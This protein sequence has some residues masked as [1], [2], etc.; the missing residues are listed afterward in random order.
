MGSQ[1]APDPSKMARWSA[2]AIECPDG[3]ELARDASPDGE[4]S[5]LWCQLVRGGQVAP[6]GPYLELYADGSTARQGL[7]R[8]GRQVGP[9]VVWSP[10]GEVES[11]RML[12]PG[13]AN[14]FIPRPEDLCPPGTI[15]DRSRG[16]DHKRRL[17]SHCHR[18]DA[19]GKEVR[20][21]P[22]VTWD[23]ETAS[24]GGTRFAL[25]EIEMYQDG[26]RHGPRQVFAG[27]SGQEALV[28]EETLEADALEGVS[29]AFFL[30]GTVREVR[31][32]AQG[33]LHGERIG[34]APQGGERWRVTYENGQVVATEGDLT[35]GGQ[36][37]PERTVP[38]VS[39]DGREEACARRYPYSIWRHGP[40]LVRDGQGQVVER[41]LYED[42]HKAQLWQAPPG[43]EIPAPVSDD[44]LVARIELL[45]G[46]RSYPALH[47]RWK[48]AAA[49]GALAEPAAAPGAS[50]TAAFEEEITVREPVPHKIWFRNN[51]TKKYPHPRTEIRD[52]VVE[53]YGL[54]PGD[55][56][57]K[58]EID[59]NRANG[60]QWPGD[61]IS[62]TDFSVVAG[63]VTEAAAQ[64][65]Y[66]LHMVE[67]WDNEAPI[68]GWHRPCRD[69][70]AVLAP[71]AGVLRFA[72]ALPGGER[73]VIED[74]SGIEYHYRL[75]R[76]LCDPLRDL[77]VVAEGFT[78]A[79]QLEVELPPSRRGQIYEWSL[80]AKR[81]DRPIGQMMAFGDDGGYGW[82][83]RFRVR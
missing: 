43:V 28:E 70:A 22:S 44:V 15:R 78:H 9:W 13:E 82:S 38:W 52:G 17:W 37:C 74:F 19:N 25:R 73:S 81:A 31:H 59:A 53:V 67:P 16:H 39:A 32:Y 45:V 48:E 63:E 79:T 1:P 35:V 58:V 49:P 80:V 26:E 18:L 56:Y 62:S 65:L 10:A 61:L 64:L 76:R 7:Y 21:G 11:V 75:T 71:A 60:A 46:E 54:P 24:G 29:R 12:W 5:A 47:A 4:R 72:W 68:P 69:E 66:T 2:E 8:G 30:D 83:L 23:E 3:A 41:G 34:Y 40:F 51:R 42:N 14:R 50:P 36:P 55:Y 20:H 6:H 33:Q 27:P 57:M 77:E